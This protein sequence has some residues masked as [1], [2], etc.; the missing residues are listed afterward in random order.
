LH[1]SIPGWYSGQNLAELVLV[2]NDKVRNSR[3][4]LALW[5]IASITAQIS[6]DGSAR[7]RVEI[8]LSFI[9]KG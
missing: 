1:V 8:T 5:L 7:F 3:M 4:P 2:A 9:T 6:V